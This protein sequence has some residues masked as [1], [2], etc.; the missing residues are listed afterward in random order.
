MTRLSHGND[1]SLESEPL[2][3][4][5]RTL[6]EEKVE[7]VHKHMKDEDRKDKHTSGGL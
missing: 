4:T 3:R 6:S 2:D 5:E 7:T 1:S